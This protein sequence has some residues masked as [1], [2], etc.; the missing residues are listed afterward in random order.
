MSRTLD[1]VIIFGA[2][3]LYCSSVQIKI[4]SV[5]I[6]TTLVTPQNQC[7]TYGCPSGI[8]TDF[9]NNTANGIMYMNYMD[10]VNDACMNMF[11]VGQIAKVQSILNT[12]R[13]AILTSDGC[14]GS[15]VVIIDAQ[16]MHFDSKWN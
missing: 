11:T 13:S 1:G 8:Q 3:T 14:S 4:L 12:S 9:C 2:V 7:I 5:P 15:N 6:L 10:Y 16:P